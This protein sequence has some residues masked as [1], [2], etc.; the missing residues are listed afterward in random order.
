MATQ[1]LDKFQPPV[2]TA[3]MNRRMRI[4]DTN[5]RHTQAT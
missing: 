4:H 5:S 2:A 1:T 3:T